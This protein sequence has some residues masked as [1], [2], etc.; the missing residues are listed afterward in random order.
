MIST[1]HLLKVPLPNV[2]EQA[3]PQEQRKIFEEEIA[4]IIEYEDEG[5]EDPV[6]QKYYE[7]KTPGPKCCGCFSVRCLNVFFVLL[8]VLSLAVPAFF[9]FMFA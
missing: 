5:I 3:A 8:T 4:K 7:V 6:Y 9:I 2:Q 1:Y